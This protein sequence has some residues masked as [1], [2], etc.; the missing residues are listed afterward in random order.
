MKNIGQHI[1]SC[2]LRFSYIGTWHYF[3]RAPCHWSYNRLKQRRRHWKQRRRR[4]R[5]RRKRLWSGRQLSWQ[6]GIKGRQSIRNQGM[7]N[8]PL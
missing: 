5:R 4:Q 8:N 7:T 2:K 6:Q 1:E 3:D